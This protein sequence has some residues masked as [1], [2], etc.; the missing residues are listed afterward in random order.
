MNPGCGDEDVG[1]D[2]TF[3]D[4][5][6]AAPA[7]SVDV[8]LDGASSCAEAGAR[9]FEALANDAARRAQVPFPVPEDA[10]P[11][12]DRR[13]GEAV[14]VIVAARDA[15]GLVIARGCENLDGR[16]QSVRV[17]LTTRPVCST[18]PSSLE[19][20]LVVDASAVMQ[21]AN[22]GLEDD[23]RSALVD[24]VIRATLPYVDVP[25]LY[26]GRSDGV[27]R[28]ERDVE[29]AVEALSFEGP[30]R[31]L[32]A[33]SLAVRQLRHAARC[34]VEPVLLWLVAGADAGSRA[35]PIDVAIGLRG[36]EADPA[37]DVFA[38]GLA[39]EEGGARLLEA[40]LP[41]ATSRTAGPLLSA[42]VLRFQLMEARS[43]F[44][45]RLR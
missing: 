7:R 13:A 10:N 35:Q 16:D 26:V 36:A 45:A 18:G 11:L 29:A 34:G 24:E 42:T 15:D 22:I 32:D 40:A 41:P 23:V 14:T 33:A 8:V 37:D 43:A 3:P 12:R 44:T 9:A 25:R 30:S 31:V 5:L 4:E 19:L 6:S 1:F 39:L 2:V 20:A 21:R 17:A 28:V 38:A 27:E